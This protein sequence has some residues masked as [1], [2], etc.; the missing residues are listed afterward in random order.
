MLHLV[1]TLFT[2]MILSRVIL[3]GLNLESWS[4]ANYMGDGQI[5]DIDDGYRWD[6]LCNMS[7]HCLQDERQES[8]SRQ[9]NYKR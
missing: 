2:M 8:L 4:L 1:V 5:L 3:E 9:Y 6:F 7:A